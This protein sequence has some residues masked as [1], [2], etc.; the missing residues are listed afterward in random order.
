MR[1]IVRN[2]S[3]ERWS[4]RGRPCSAGL[5][6]RSARRRAIQEDYASGIKASEI[7]KVAERCEKRHVGV[8]DRLDDAAD[9]VLYTWSIH[10]AARPQRL[11]LPAARGGCKL[12]DIVPA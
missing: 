1:T 5:A 7:Y 8:I 4:Q 3:S 12:D 9:G 6:I 10:T 2:R 11:C